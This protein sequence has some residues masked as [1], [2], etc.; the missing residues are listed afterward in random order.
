[1]N[2]IIASL[3]KISSSKS[4]WRMRLGDLV[5]AHSQPQTQ[6]QL[7]R[8]EVGHVATGN[9]NVVSDTCHVISHTPSLPPPVRLQLSRALTGV[10]KFLTKLDS[11]YE[12]DGRSA[13]EPECLEVDKN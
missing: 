3:R 5:L 8:K 9:G 2:L 6:H 10:T 11:G 1:M 13:W 12:V 4:T 7:V